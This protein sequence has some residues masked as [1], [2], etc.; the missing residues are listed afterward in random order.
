MPDPYGK[1]LPGVGKQIHT[2]RYRGVDLRRSSQ[3][4]TATPGGATNDEHAKLTALF[5]GNAITVVDPGLW[6]GEGMAFFLATF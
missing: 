5:Y 6:P 4:P 1:P 2:S 3:H